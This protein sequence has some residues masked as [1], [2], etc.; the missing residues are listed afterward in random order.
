MLVMSL[1]LVI[2]A[3]PFAV[4]VAVLLVEVV[5]AIAIQDRGDAGVP[6]VGDVRPSVAVLVP[7][8]NESRGILTTIEGIKAQLLPGDRLVVVADN[9]SD[10]TAAVAATAGA[11]VVERHDPVRLGKGYALDFGLRLLSADPPQVVIMIDAD[12]RLGPGA[13]DYLAVACETSGRPVQALDLM[14]AP[15]SSSMNYKVAEFAWRVKNWVRPLGLSAL[16]L[17]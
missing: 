15:Q 8:H 3:G 7:A 16:G 2:V 13:I 4:L 14:V 1:M 17:P 9:C 5:A 11:Q 6:D 12:C 10:D